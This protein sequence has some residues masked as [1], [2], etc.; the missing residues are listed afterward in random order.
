MKSSFVILYDA[1]GFHGVSFLLNWVRFN[2]KYIDDYAA[3][4]W[5]NYSKLHIF[6]TNHKA[7]TY[8]E[9]LTH[10]DGCISTLSWPSLKYTTSHETQEQAIF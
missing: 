10:S 7:D 9:H 5:E 8:S 1:D 3:Q 6:A 4:E 2:L